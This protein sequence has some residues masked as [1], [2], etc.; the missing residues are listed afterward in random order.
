MAT[1]KIIIDREEKPKQPKDKHGRFVKVNEPDTRQ[2]Y[3]K[4]GK[5]N[6]IDGKYGMQ[7]R[8]AKGRFVSSN[9]EYTMYRTKEKRAIQT[10]ETY[11]RAGKYK[12][13]DGTV[14]TYKKG[15]PKVKYVTAYSDWTKIKV[16]DA[17][18]T[19]R[20]A[21][22]RQYGQY[23]TQETK[24]VP[25]G[26]T[27][28]VDV[29]AKTD[30]LANNIKKGDVIHKKGEQRYRKRKVW[31]DWK[32]ITTQDKYEPKVDYNKLAKEV[33]LDSRSQ[34]EQRDLPIIPTNTVNPDDV[35][36]INKDFR[37]YFYV[38]GGEGYK[39]SV[40]LDAPFS[41]DDYDYDMETEH[42]EVRIWSDE[43][44]SY[45]QLYKEFSNKKVSK[46]GKDYKFRI[47]PD[48]F[49]IDQ[50]YEVENNQ[51]SISIEKW[52]DV[53]ARRTRT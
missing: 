23:R 40:G 3:I 11:K 48:T 31:S 29:K 39:E 45:D 8:N 14:R 51:P 18:D 28:K 20:K 7:F 53:L 32:N 46:K 2:L 41:D 13:I 6:V 27:Y 22:K 16:R 19:G 9:E 43:P 10:G 4:K 33:Y 5:S 37:R 1:K 12:D 47:K 49:H 25:T 38:V 26:K 42:V 24:Y 17:K 34:N 36:S 44:M 50:A 52:V 21:T 35:K 30:D 15:D